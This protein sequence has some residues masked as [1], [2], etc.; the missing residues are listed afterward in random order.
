MDKHERNQRDRARQRARY[1]PTNSARWRAIR[2]A[3]LE[4]FP[5]CA[6]CGEPAN[7]V[8]HIAGDTSRNAIGTELQS[9]CKPCHSRKTNGHGIVGCDVNGWPL[10]PAHHWQ[11]R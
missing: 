5:L 11:R 4:R 1:L 2:A 9:L 10:D 6:H 7:E 8:D 3:Q